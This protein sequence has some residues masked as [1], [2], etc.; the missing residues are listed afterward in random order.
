LVVRSK[1][2]PL[3]QLCRCHSE[4]IFRWRERDAHPRSWC[5]LYKGTP[6]LIYAIIEAK[7]WWWKNGKIEGYHI[8]KTV[9]GKAVWTAKD[10]IKPSGGVC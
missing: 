1:A 5:L 7:S 9:P 10:G 6:G 2:G 3:D 4:E 8:P